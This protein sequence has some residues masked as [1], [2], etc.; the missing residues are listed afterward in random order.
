MSTIRPEITSKQIDPNHPAI[1]RL[2]MEYARWA[3]DADFAQVD[4]EEY[5]SDILSCFDEWE[6]DGFK[7]AKHLEDKSGIDGD[8]GL[9]E[10]LSSVVSVKY[11]LQTAAYSKWIAENNLVID[12][13]LK[14]RKITY[15]Q[16]YRKGE[17]Y[18]TGIYADKYQVTIGKSPTENGGFV[19]N[20][21]NIQ[22]T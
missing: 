1:E 9:V 11:T 21:E 2:V 12:P 4:K 13:T 17:G 6:L 3:D 19:I 18:I 10:I 14:G 8:E 16:N 22:L 7:L 20:F 5:I 15:A